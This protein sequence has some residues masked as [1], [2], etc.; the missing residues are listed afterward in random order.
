MDDDDETDEFLDIKADQED[1][2]LLNTQFNMDTGKSK[3]VKTSRWGAISK[4]ILATR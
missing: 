4:A 3:I 2:P 1:L